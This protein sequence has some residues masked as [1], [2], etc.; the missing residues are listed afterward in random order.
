MLVGKPQRY[1]RLREGNIHLVDPAAAFQQPAK[2]AGIHQSSVWPDLTPVAYFQP[3]SLLRK[4]NH[5]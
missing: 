1:L 4:D 5:N 3:L 2:E